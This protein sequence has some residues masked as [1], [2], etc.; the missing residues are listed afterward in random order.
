MVLEV[1]KRGGQ[2]HADTRYNAVPGLARL[3]NLNAVDA[4]AEML[5][6][7]AISI[8][9]SG[10]QDPRLQ[11]YKRIVILHNALNA[12]ISLQE[13]NGQLDL[14][15]LH[16]AVQKLLAA[17]PKVIQSNAVRK[18]LVSQAEKA[19]EVLSR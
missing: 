15:T 3:G 9:T 12:A 14:L 7:E 1:E 6:I 19:L 4:I 17:A 5:D 10:E 18:R 2:R 8:S 16:D 11:N 13:Y